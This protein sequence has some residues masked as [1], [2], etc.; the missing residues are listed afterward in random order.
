MKKILFCL[1]IFALVF[2]LAGCGAKEKLEEKFAEKIFEKAGG[3]NLDIDGDKVSIKGENGEKITFGDNK[4]PKSE[5]VKNIP[6]FKDGTVSAVLESSD[7]VVI[8][9]ESVRKKDS[10][11]Y[12]EAIKKEFPLETFEMD[13]EDMTSFSGKN[14]AGVS[15]ALMYTSEMLTITVTSPQQ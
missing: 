10:F 8:T 5:L 13:S 11:S 4:W 15:I 3:G 12:F 14:D 1:L 9:L 2:S 7:S 6:E